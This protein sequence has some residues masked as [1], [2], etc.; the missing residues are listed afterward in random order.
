[1]SILQNLSFFGTF[2]WTSAAM[3]SKVDETRPF[4]SWLRAVLLTRSKKSSHH[5]EDSR[6][7]F[8]PISGFEDDDDGHAL[9]ICK[10]CECEKSYSS[11]A[12]M[13]ID[14]LI[15]RYFPI[16]VW[17]LKWYLRNSV[18]NIKWPS[19]VQALYCPL[20][21]QSNLIPANFHTHTHNR[22]QCKCAQVQTERRTRKT[23]F[24]RRSMKQNCFW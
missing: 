16:F 8:L 11:P 9:L 2:P 23:R 20:I 5:K 15:S 19:D 3:V 18:I 21:N 17:I 4:W 7:F 22:I 13:L 10:W 24:V 6:T 14:R 12:N 1:M